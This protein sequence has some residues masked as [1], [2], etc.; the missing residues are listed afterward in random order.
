MCNLYSITT[1]QEV[2]RALFRAVNQY[3]GNLAPMPGVFAG[4]EFVPSPQCGETTATIAR[5]LTAKPS[6]WAMMILGFAAVSLLA[7]QRE[8][9]TTPIAA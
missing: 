7:Y 3:V 9:K 8:N 4:K 2:V 1:H 5:A 6:T